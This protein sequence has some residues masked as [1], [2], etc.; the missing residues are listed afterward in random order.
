[1][2]TSEEASAETSDA[3]P[4]ATSEAAAGKRPRRLRRLLLP[5]FALALVAAFA[6][7]V[8]VVAGTSGHRHA[9]VADVPE[10]PVALVLGAGV[11][12][13]GL[14]TRV[15]A[16]RLELAADLYFA[17]KVEVL[18]VSGDNSVEHYNETDT[19]RD[20]LVAAGV[21]AEHIA[22]DY[23]GFSTWESCVRA[24]EVFGVTEA[25]VVTQDFHLPRAVSLCRAAGIDAV[26]VADAAAQE[27]VWATRY[28]WAREVPAAVA[29]LGSAVFRPDPTFLGPYETAVDDAL[30]AAREGGE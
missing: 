25:T 11:R 10:R 3:T 13:D 30:A 2:T 21:P 9:T 16:R 23:A 22:A 5:L 15:L 28:G 19:M 7:F 6:P 24:H 4:G 8:W 14:P 12:D 26:G 29:A 18:L 17:G 20:H 27:R 1:M